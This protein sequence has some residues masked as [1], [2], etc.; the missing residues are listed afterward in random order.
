MNMKSQN[1]LCP[2]LF[3]LTKCVRH[4]RSIRKFLRQRVLPPLTEVH[5]RPEEGSTLRNKLCRLLT[6]PFTQVRGLVEEFLFILCKENVMRMVKYTGYGNAAGFLAK[7]GAMLGGSGNLD[8]GSGAQYSSDSE[9]SDTEEYKKYKSQINIMTGCYEK[10]HP[11]PMASMSEEQKEYEALELVKKLD[12]L[13]R[14]GVV[15]PCR[16]GEDGRP[17]PVGQVLEL[18]EDISQQQ[19]KPT[20]DDD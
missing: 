15:Q 2:T 13:A 18:I 4:H 6:T 12:Q 10:P 20:Q 7:R 19:P 9:D 5:T 17:E 14:D 3:L 1:D 8:S 16:I 11:N